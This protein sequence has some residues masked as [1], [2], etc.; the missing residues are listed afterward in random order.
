MNAATHVHRNAQRQGL[1]GTRSG[2]SVAR[3]SCD[4][5][6]VAP[7]IDLLKDED[8][9]V[10]LSAVEAL[11]KLGDRD[12]VEPLIDSISDNDWRVRMALVSALAF[13]QNISRQKLCAQSDRESERRRHF[14]R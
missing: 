8:A 1:E 5:R 12:S 4:K 14:R 7:L 10:R 11:G 9:L 6:A 3:P 2:S 13:V